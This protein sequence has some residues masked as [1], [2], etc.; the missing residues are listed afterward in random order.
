[1]EARSLKL[2][3][4][5]RFGWP[6]GR[7]GPKP[8]TLQLLSQVHRQRAGSEVELLDLAHA[9]IWDAGVTGSSWG[10]VCVLCFS[11]TVFSTLCLHGVCAQGA[12]RC[13]EPA[14]WTGGGQESWWP[15]AAAHAAV[16]LTSHLLDDALTELSQSEIGGPCPA[17]T[18]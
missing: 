15:A 2:L 9:L 13:R 3:P 4:G 12:A 11:L 5:T 18:A 17:W 16:C 1:M 8:S 14:V 7:Q 6:C 10:L